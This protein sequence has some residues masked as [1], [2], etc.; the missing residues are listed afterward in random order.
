MSGTAGNDTITGTGGDDTIDGYGG[1]DHID[2]G[3][4]ND[5]VYGGTGDD[6]LIGNLGND[7]LVGDAGNDLLT[8]DAG[9]D[10]LVGGAG[11][12][13]F[14]GGTGLDYIDYSASG[15]AVDVNLT[16]GAFSGG[17]ATGDSLISGVDA[18]IGSSH[19]DTLTGFDAQST[20]PSN[21]YTNVLSGGAGNDLIY[22]LGGNDSLYG[23]AD[24]DTIFGGTGEDHIDGGSGN[25]TLT[26]DAGADTIQGGDD[27]DM[28]FGGLGDV[29]DGGE[30]GNDFD[31]L[32]LSGSGYHVHVTYTSGDPESGTATF[33]DLSGVV[34]GTMTFSHIEQVIACFTLGTLVSTRGGEVPI[35]TMRP[36]DLVLTRDNGY[37]PLRWIGRRPLSAA[38]LRANPR[39]LPVR[40]ARDAL[41]PG[42]PTR[43]MQVSPQHRLLIAHPRAEL[44]FAEYEVLVPAL[45]LLG[46]PGISRATAQDVTYVHL[47]FDQHEVIHA[48]GIWSESFQPGACVTSALSTEQ[49]AE[50]LALF[51]ELAEGRPYPAARLSLK[52]REA[53]VLLSAL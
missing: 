52:A 31:T 8:G 42:L 14:H 16:T 25:D 10:T 28:I 47:L 9:D 45:H 23:G 37:R 50:L 12:D 20:D 21:T 32:D 30:G 5:L 51:P 48:D 43:D 17:D 39:F 29:V 7:L 53:R 27:R 4:G 2:A 35:E 36:G 40:L 46:R 49:G 41:G 33:S 13:V 6:T 44:L 22:G 19:D 15:A 26:G 34:Q 1:N 3:A 38:D 18:I 24:N 11:A